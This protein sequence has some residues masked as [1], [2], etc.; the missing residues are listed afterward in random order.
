[1]HVS[2]TQCCTHRSAQRRTEPG[3]LAST[4]PS[5][6]TSASVP[7]ALQVPLPESGLRKKLAGAHGQTLRDVSA[8]PAARCGAGTEH[9]GS[10]AAWAPQIAEP[11]GLGLRRNLRARLL[12]PQPAAPPPPSAPQLRLPPFISLPLASRAPAQP[13]PLG[14]PAPGASRDLSDF[15]LPGDRSPC[16]SFP[17]APLLF[18]WFLLFLESVLKD[19][20]IGYLKTKLAKSSEFR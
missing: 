9:Q 6:V 16:L 19:K 7:G 2:P 3:Y 15:R 8:R 10:R 11:G 13:E 20:S 5:A 18:S 1:M 4:T 14:P 17:K 12:P